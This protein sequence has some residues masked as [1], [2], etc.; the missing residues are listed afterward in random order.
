MSEHVG[1]KM[2]Q[3]EDAEITTE[4]LNVEARYAQ[5]ETQ[6]VRILMSMTMNEILEIY[7]EISSVDPSLNAD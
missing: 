3:N 4:A 2:Y 1:F 7:E 5:I 6:V